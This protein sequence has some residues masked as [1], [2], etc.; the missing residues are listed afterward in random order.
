MSEMTRGDRIRN[1]YV[2]G[3]RGVASIMEKTRENRFD[4]LG[5]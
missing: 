3:S 4:G 5:M 2:K 1:E